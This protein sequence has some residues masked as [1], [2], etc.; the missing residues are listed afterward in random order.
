VRPGPRCLAAA[1]HACLLSYYDVNADS[2]S[3]ART[4][5]FDCR[6]LEA[7]AEFAIFFHLTQPIIIARTTPTSSL[8]CC[9]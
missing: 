8:M 2:C 5:G 7:D 9:S 1:V 4:S 6:H 3:P